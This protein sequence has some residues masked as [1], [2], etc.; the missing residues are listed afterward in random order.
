MG[1]AVTIGGVG[2]LV[3]DDALAGFVRAGCDALDLDGRSLC[4]IVPDGTRSCPLP[5]VLTAIRDAVIDRVSRLSVLVALGTHQRMSATALSEHLGKD[6]AGDLRVQV[7]NHEWWDETTFVDLGQITAARMRQASQGRLTEPVPV[8]VNRLVT[9]HDVDLVVG[10]VFPHE[11]IGFSGGSKYFFPGVSGPEVIDATHWLGALITSSA[12]I[13]VLGPTPVRHVVEEAAALIQAEKQCLSLVVAS[14]THDVRFA[15]F[16]SC[17]DSQAAAAQV[18]AR[19]HISYLDHPVRRVLSLI[20]ERYDDLWTGAK[21]MYKVDPVVADGGQVIL[22]APHISVA[23]ETH[24]RFLAEIGYHCRDYFLGQPE[25]FT[26][27]PR[28]VLAH[29]T[30]VRGGGSWDAAHG[31]NCRITVTLA[32]GIPGQTT[33]ALGLDYLDPDSVDAAEFA[34]DPDT[35]VVPNAGEV[36]F[37]LQP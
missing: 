35:L 10:P 26:A 18:S 1:Q 20:P 23:S 30:H 7:R 15:A 2:E 8:R 22:Y 14:G 4:V 31:E 33:H 37:R 9:D 19:T 16:G 34:A 11:V 27:I 21:G 3:D 13:G 17:Q 36:L 28:T 5:A 6:L 25:R 12:I 24:G 29:S 32:T